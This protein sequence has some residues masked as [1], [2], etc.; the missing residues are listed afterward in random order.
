MET[1]LEITG[2]LNVRIFFLSVPDT[3]RSW[4]TSLTFVTTA[5]LLLR[6]TF[7]PYALVLWTLKAQVIVRGSNCTQNVHLQFIF[8]F[9][10]HTVGK[11]Q[12][13]Y[14]IK[15]RVTEKSWS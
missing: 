3:V 10:S 14:E 5:E 12:V 9:K 13:T 8:S 11:S 6:T 15:K 2:C 4:F 7:S 1:H